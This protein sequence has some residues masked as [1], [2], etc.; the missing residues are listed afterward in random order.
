[1][2]GYF[3]LQIWLPLRML[4]YWRVAALLPIIVLV[5]L[6]LHAG[7]ALAME[8]NLWPILIIFFAPLGLLYLGALGIAHAVHR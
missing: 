4:G 1:V 2:P 3:I 6:L 8:S 7:M 5:P